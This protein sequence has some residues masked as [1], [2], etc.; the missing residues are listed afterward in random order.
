MKKNFFFFFIE[1]CEQKKNKT[2]I[3]CVSSKPSR[4]VDT[5]RLKT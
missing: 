3:L 2:K 1:H 5:S 4:I